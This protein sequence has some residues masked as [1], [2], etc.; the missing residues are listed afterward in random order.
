MISANFPHVPDGPGW[1]DMMK[2]Y[3]LQIENGKPKLLPAQVYWLFTNIEE[4]SPICLMPVFEAL[5]QKEEILRTAQ[6]YL[7]WEKNMLPPNS[8]IGDLNRELCYGRERLF[9]PEDV[10]I[11]EDLTHPI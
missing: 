2:D 3:V 4:V 1:W 7:F 9:R 8:P 11:I 10:K 5:G 6:R